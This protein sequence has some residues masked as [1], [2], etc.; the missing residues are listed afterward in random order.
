MM[1]CEEIDFSAYHDRALED[2]VLRQIDIH[3]QYC[4]VCMSRYSQEV[5]LVTGLS[6]IPAWDPPKHFVPHVMYRVRQEIYS[7][8]VPSEERRFSLVTAAGGLVLLVVIVFLGGIQHNFFEGTFGWAQLPLK[9]LLAVLQTMNT[10]TQS[11]GSWLYSSSAALLPTIVLATLIA[12]FMLIKLLTRYERLMLRDI[13][14]RIHRGG[15]E[16]TT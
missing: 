2:S 16:K 1:R 12:G 15:N 8:I 11:G 6:E 13:R 9:S 4:A 14:P 5:R 7:Q 3:L 10:V